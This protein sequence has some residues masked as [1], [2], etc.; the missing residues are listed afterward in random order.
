M[1]VQKKSRKFVNF[2]ILS[3]TIALHTRRTPQACAFLPNMALE[4]DLLRA[5]FSS[6]SVGARPLLSSREILLLSLLSLYL[7][8]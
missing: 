5:F 1:N 7:S 4:R 3:I 8:L 6:L 2:I